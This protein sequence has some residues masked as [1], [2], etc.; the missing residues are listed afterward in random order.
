MVLDELRAYLAGYLGAL[1]PPLYEGVAVTDLVALPDGRFALGTDAGGL[2]ARNVVVAAGPYRHPVVPDAAR[3]L[4][5]GIRQL[6]SGEYRS[7]EALAPGAVLVVGTGQSGCQIAEDLH[8]AGRR[9]HLATGSAPR[10]ARR[11]RGRDV[12]RWLDDMGYYATTVDDHPLGVAKRANVNHYVTG[13]DGGHDIDLRAFALQGMVLHGRLRS[14]E[15]TGLGFGDDL[16]A[17]L[18]GA[19]A[20]AEGIKDTIDAYIERA[21]IDAPPE[22]RYVP[23][24]QP[25][26]GP[27]SLDLEAAGVSTVIWATGFRPDHDWIRLPVF[28]PDGRPHHHRG[29]TDVAGVYFLGLPWQHTWGSARFSGIAVDAAHVA[30]AIAARSPVPVRAGPG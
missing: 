12:V 6:H 11:Y 15:G 22:A 19:D 25:P 10:V 13:R 21:G 14:V 7:P 27:S 8:L 2:R 17:N 18:D 16:A 28:G 26:P 24:W 30:D 20:V 9:V 23:V 29:V 1:R 4:P 5:A 3:A